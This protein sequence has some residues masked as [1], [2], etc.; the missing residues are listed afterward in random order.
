MNSSANPVVHLKD[1]LPSDVSSQI[2]DSLSRIADQ[3]TGAAQNW[4]SKAKS[5]AKSTDSLVRS[6]PWQ[7]VGVV[8]LV[9]LAAGLLASR[10]VRQARLRRQAA[11]NQQHLSGG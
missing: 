8:A 3:L 11:V 10:Q 6:S 7:A 9:S 4:S 5:A 1:R 2:T